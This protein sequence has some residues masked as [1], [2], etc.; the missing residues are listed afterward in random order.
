MGRAPLR[1]ASSSGSVTTRAT[2]SSRFTMSPGSSRRTPTGARRGGLRPRAPGARVARPRG[3]GRDDPLRRREGTVVHPWEGGR[4][5]IK[6]P[7]NQAR[8]NSHSLKRL[9]ERGKRVADNRFFASYAVAFPDTRMKTASLK[10]DAPRE[11]VIDGDD[12]R[13]F[14]KRLLDVLAYWD[15]KDK[16]AP[17]D[18]AESTRSSA[19]SPTRSRFRRRSRSSSPRN[20]ASSC[21]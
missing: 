16:R 9:L 2:T 5:A 3:Q 1:S 21:G 4:C 15:A 13:S 19:C 20:S 14:E 8:Q 18:A 10:P 7:F 17:L 6:D 11:I 12:L